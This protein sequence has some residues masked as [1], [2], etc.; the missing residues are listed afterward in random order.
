MDLKRTLITGSNGS[1]I[2][3]QTNKLLA[4]FVLLIFAE[5]Q[6]LID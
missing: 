1:R 6:I 4:F 5:T 2:R 3:L